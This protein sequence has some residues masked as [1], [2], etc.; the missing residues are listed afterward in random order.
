MLHQ[1][2]YLCGNPMCGAMITLDM[3]HL[4]PVSQDGGDRPEN[5]IAL[6]P[7]CHRRHHQGD[8]PEA[9][10][11]AWKTV[12]LALSEAYDI[13]SIDIL[14][15]LKKMTSV[16]IRGDALLQIPG[17]IASD[18]ISVTP[19]RKII[20]SHKVIKYLGEDNSTSEDGYLM[21]LTPKG[22][23]LIE[24]WASGKVV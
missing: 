6:C 3:H 9:S 24:N 5:L 20:Q 16:F 19:F 23:T 15:M 2:G 1:C 12:H 17:L 8:I 14:F 10:L 4:K 13:R 22:L 21:A 18:L 11:R 7:N